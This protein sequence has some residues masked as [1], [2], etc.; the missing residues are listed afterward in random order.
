MV[1]GN[2]KCTIKNQRGW[3]APG[4]AVGKNP[5][6][7][8]GDMGL[9]PGQGRLHMPRGNSAPGSVTAEPVPHTERRCAVSAGA[10]SGVAALL[11][12]AREK[13]AQMRTQCHQK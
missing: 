8:A 12:P 9:L 2:E 11:A 6:A 1:P 5:P 7:N 13:P 4:I 3:D 10:P